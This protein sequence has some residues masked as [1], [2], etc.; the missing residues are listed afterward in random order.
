MSV[1]AGN[2]SKAGHGAEHNLQFNR[3]TLDDPW[4]WIA[5]GWRDM[6]AMPMISLIY[7]AVFSLISLS[8]S[9]TLFIAEWSSVVLA[10]GAGF[11]L[12]GPMLAVGLYEASRR[13]EANEPVSLRDVFFVEVASPAQLAFLGA[14][15]MLVLLAWMR[16]ATL[17]FA[18]FFGLDGFPPIADFLPTVMFT[19]HGLGLAVVGTAVGAIIAFIVFAISALSAPLLLDK[20]MD[21]VSA[22]LASVRCIR[23][24]FGPMLLWAWIIAMVMTV[25]MATLFLGMIVAFPLVGHATWHAYRACLKD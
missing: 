19:P 21:A 18:L 15:L 25:G 1:S 3:L 11:M 2:P 16:V 23:E 8:L 20:N 13:L 14:L 7:G 12:V 6:W 22:I 5:A 9:A 17:L 4:R 24:N 10:L